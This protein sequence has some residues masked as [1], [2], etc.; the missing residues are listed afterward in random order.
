MAP[1]IS[2]IHN[3]FAERKSVAVA[4]FAATLATDATIILILSKFS[5]KMY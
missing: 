4:F 3:I 1:F 2:I 5:L